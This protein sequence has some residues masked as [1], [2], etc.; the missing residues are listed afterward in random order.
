[1]GGSNMAK[2]TVFECDICKT[3]S[4]KITRL[5]LETSTILL[6]NEDNKATVGTPMISH[7]DVCSDQCAMVAL[8]KMLKV[9]I[10]EKGEAQLQE[11]PKLL[12]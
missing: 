12:S 10:T 7:C 1:M 4:K 3:Q 5:K 11:Q 8:S 2:I 9:D 6:S